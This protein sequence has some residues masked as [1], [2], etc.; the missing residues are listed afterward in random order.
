[1]DNTQL[2][3][4]AGKALAPELDL[5]LPG[6]GIAPAFVLPHNYHLKIPSIQEAE[7]WA[8]K[9]VRKRG[10]FYFGDATSF[11]RYFNE[12]K[13]PD[14]RIFADFGKTGGF[15]G[16]VGYLNFHGAE[17]SFHDHACY[18]TLKPSSEW[19]NW[20]EN[21]SND[22]TQAQFAEFLEDHQSLIL[23]PS[24]ADLLELIQNLEAKSHCYIDSA[25]K[26]Q[27]STI[28]LRISEEVE[29][30]HGSATQSGE[31]TLP[32]VLTVGIPPFEGV[33]A[34]TLQA[35]LRYKVEQRKITF[36]YKT[37][38]PEATIRDVFKSLLAVIAKETE[39]EPFIGQQ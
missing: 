8:G 13:T 6:G 35:R 33:P 19:T 12:H 15:V 26:L 3:L 39:V 18:Y 37:I 7:Q 34:Y 2:I 14:S 22:M 21:D 16:F 1:M 5:V 17:P 28:K 30:K 11:T 29:L 36:W 24:G 20:M 38:T 10:C 9:P 25:L 32:A 31:L 27:S 23:T 4:D